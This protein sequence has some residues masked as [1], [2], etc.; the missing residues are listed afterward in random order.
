MRRLIITL[1]VLTALFVGYRSIVAPGI[2]CNADYCIDTG[3]WK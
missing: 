3:T 1:A 2:H